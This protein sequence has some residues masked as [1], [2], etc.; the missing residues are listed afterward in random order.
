MKLP[1]LSIDTLAAFIALSRHK[2]LELAGRELSVSASAVHKRLRVAE[3]ALG[4]RLFHVSNEG[5][6]PTKEGQVLYL[7]ALRIMEQASLAEEKVRAV[8]E[9]LQRNILVGHSTYLAP[10]LLSFVMRLRDNASGKLRIEHRSGLTPALVQQVN[11]GILHAAFGELI[12]APRSLLVRQLFEEPLVVCLPKEHR[13]AGRHVIRPQELDGEPTIA[14]SREYLPQQHMEIED[15]LDQFGAKTRI[16]AD[17]FGPAEAL[18]LVAQKIGICFVPESHA[19]NPL[20]TARPL[21]IRTLTRKSGLYVRDD[22]RHQ[23]VTTLIDLT[24]QLVTPRI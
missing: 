1:S 5:L 3:R 4:C 13:L 12:E 19:A 9:L 15:L 23:A 21:S 22:S 16:V 10:H 20:A 2:N 6:M 24:V 18:V 7:D 14:V 17:A 8:R 11:D